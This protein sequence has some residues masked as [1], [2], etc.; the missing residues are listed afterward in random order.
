LRFFAR[1]G[2]PWFVLSLL[3]VRLRGLLIPFSLLL[4]AFS[5]LLVA[6]GLFLVAHGLLLIAL[7]LLLIA[8]CLFLI[9]LGLLLV[10]CRLLLI[11]LG[12]LL[13][14]FGLFLIVLVFTLGELDLPLALSLA[15]RAAGGFVLFGAGLFRSRLAFVLCGLLRLD[16]LR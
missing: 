15:A 11:A 16:S 4:I 6:F 10:A 12:L 13:I 7:R 14:K 3:C 9:T 5:L 8:A 2:R 1:S